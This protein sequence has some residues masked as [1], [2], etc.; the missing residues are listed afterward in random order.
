MARR[1]LVGMAPHFHQW[2]AVFLAAAVAGVAL[3]VELAAD[4]GTVTDASSFSGIFAFGYK[5]RNAESTFSQLDVS[6]VIFSLSDSVSGTSRS[7][8]AITSQLGV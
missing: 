3:A 1:L 2:A 4:V 8:R 7:L 5:L 6:L